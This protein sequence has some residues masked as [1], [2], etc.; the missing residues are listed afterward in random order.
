MYGHT[1]TQAHTPIYTHT[2]TH[3][4]HAHAIVDVA[5]DKR[6]GRSEGR[7]ERR[8]EGSNVGTMGVA[9][10]QVLMALRKSTGVPITV[11]LEDGH[12]VR[13][14][15]NYDSQTKSIRFVPRAEGEGGG[16]SP[17]IPSTQSQQSSPSPLSPLAPRCSDS[18]PLAAASGIIL[19]K[20]EIERRVDSRARIDENCAAI[21]FKD[22]S[23]PLG[24]DREKGHPLENEGI[25]GRSGRGRG[26]RLSMTETAE[27]GSEKALLLYFDQ[28]KDKDL[29]AAAYRQTLVDFVR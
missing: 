29:F 15:A 17:A 5:V 22:A 26:K 21:C 13:C 23:L 20:V 1:N 28:S 25:E 24:R 14:S 7:P 18:F 9:A 12:G 10:E 2:H 16:A 4:T 19:D 8:S 3:T 27:K 6:R 11:L